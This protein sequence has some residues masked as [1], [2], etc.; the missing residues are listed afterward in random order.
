VWAAFALARVTGESKSQVALLIELWREDR[1][2]AGLRRGAVRYDV[3]Q[4]LE[5]LGADAG[6]ARDI[7]VEALLDDKTPPGTHAHVAR[8]GEAYAVYERVR[9]RLER[10][11][12]VSRKVDEAADEPIGRGGLKEVVHGAA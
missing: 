2:D 6:P 5:L 3:A 4:A 7:L 12:A 10:R 8:A 11:K 9:K 1:G